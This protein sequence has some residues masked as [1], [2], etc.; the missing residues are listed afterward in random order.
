MAGRA[1]AWQVSE[2]VLIHDPIWSLSIARVSQILPASQV[3]SSSTS[4]GSGTG[5]MPDW[6]RLAVVLGLP[7]HYL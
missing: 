3:L 5:P 1:H 2:Q 6:P 7:K 4:L